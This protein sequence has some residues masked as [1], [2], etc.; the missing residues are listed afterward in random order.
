MV[1]LVGVS[2]MYT[3]DACH[4]MPGVGH[5]NLPEQKLVVCCQGAMCF[6]KIAFFS[7]INLSHPSPTFKKV[8]N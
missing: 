2:N 7:L 5:P 6:A 8:Q 3:F 1:Y 4:F